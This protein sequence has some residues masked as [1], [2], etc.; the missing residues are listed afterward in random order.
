MRVNLDATHGL[1][2]AEAVTM[3]L[4]ETIGRSEAHHLME[5]A[6]KR[7]VAEKTN[8]RDVLAKDPD[9]NV[10]LSPDRLE[11]LFEPMAYQGVAQILIDQ[12]LVS[13]DDK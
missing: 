11:K 1:I 2:M 5:A 10:H 12:L 3:A 4:A 6:S 7:V 9:I 13:L 8:L